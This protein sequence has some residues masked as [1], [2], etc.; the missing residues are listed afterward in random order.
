MKKYSSLGEKTNF[1]KYCPG[2]LYLVETNKIDYINEEINNSIDMNDLTAKLNQ[3][4]MILYL[5]QY[6]LKKLEDEIV[7]VL[8]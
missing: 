7:I 4:L 2:D 3:F 8:I 1:S 5:F 6:H